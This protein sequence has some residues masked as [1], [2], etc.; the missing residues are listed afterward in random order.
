[1]DPIGFAFEHYDAFGRFRNTE[2]NDP[3]D[4]SATIYNANAT[5]GNV[6]F[7]GVAGLETYLAGDA[8]AKTCLVR[9]WS[10]YAFGS[11][12]WAQDALHLSTRSPGV[13]SGEYALQRRA[14]R[15]IHAPHFTSRVPAP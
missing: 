14:E 3:I 11:A 10:F 12:S 7:N 6:A 8:D 5:D 9:Y 4:S 2:N 15:I 1:M 13:A